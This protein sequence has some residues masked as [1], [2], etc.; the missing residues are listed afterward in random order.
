MCNIADSGHGGPAGGDG[1]GGL[2]HPL[3][4]DYVEERLEMLQVSESDV[5]QANGYFLSVM[6]GSKTCLFCKKVLDEN[7]INTGPRL[8][9]LREH[10]KTTLL[11]VRPGTN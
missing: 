9:Y 11:F 3:F 10:L 5:K 2:L 1:E 4:K 6:D 8:K 7:H